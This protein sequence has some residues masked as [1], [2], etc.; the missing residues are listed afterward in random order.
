MALQNR[1][2]LAASAILVG[3]G[4]LTLGVIAMRQR[5]SAPGST[6]SST[7]HSFE[8][9]AGARFIAPEMAA[10]APVLVP[11]PLPKFP[12]A[13]AIWGSLGRDASGHVWFG[14]S[15]E[16]VDIPSAHLFEYV[17]D[18]T[19]LLD[20]GDVVSQ[21][22]RSGVY[23][24]GEGQA[25]IHSRIVQGADG[26][27][28]FASM[29]EAG[30]HGNGSHLP[31]WGGHLW[32]VKP[33]TSV[34]EHLL[35]TPE[36]L[37]AVSGF[38]RWIYALGYFD[39]VLYQFDS[40]TKRTRSVHVGSI[41]GH[42]SRNFVVDE[43][44]HVYVPRLSPSAA[45]SSKIETT[46]VELDTSLQ[47]VAATPIEHYSQFPNED[48]HGIVGLQD[49]ADHSIVVITDRGFLYR[50][51]PSPDG[52]ATI[53]DLGWFHPKG[54]SYV[55]SLFTDDGRHRLMGVSHRQWNNE[56]N[57]EWLVYDFT[58]RSSVAVPLEIPRV[59][60]QE[61]VHLAL[62]GSMVRDNQGRAYVAGTYLPPS[63]SLPL[64]FQLS[65]PAQP[66]IKR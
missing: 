2:A 57:Y 42:I 6:Q 46:I 12:G 25:K 26:F 20:R 48:S 55:A 37:I 50:I 41:G 43:H 35:S 10:T 34:W 21:L 9:L 3:T 49:L 11:V 28:Y 51:V 31:T 16:G 58:T 39:H 33:G 15:A 40:T 59:G 64:L 27:M 65:D 19:A 24:P 32:R 36:A 23:R 56:T 29:D 22:K 60:G 61:I 7:L 62:Y 14:V 45:D 13:Y 38:G 47:V 17:P 54:E 53:Q 18:T 44:G 63:G 8:D 30:E 5:G 1:A 52:P 4:L 66:A